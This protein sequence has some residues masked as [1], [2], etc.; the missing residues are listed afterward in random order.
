MTNGLSSAQAK[1]LTIILNAAIVILIGA[2]SYLFV[3]QSQL[4]VKQAEMA[5]KFVM[6][7]QYRVDTQRAE[8]TVCRLEAKFEVFEQKVDRKLDAILQ[9]QRDTAR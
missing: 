6:V 5:E 9:Y 2:T 1:I 8:S 7:S 4:A 3:N